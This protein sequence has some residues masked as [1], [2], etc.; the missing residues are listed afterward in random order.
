MTPYIAQTRHTLYNQVLALFFPSSTTP[1]TPHYLE[2]TDRY[3][4]H[5]RR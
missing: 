4:P 1:A 2:F 3:F 5:Y